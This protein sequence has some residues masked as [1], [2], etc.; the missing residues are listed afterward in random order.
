MSIAKNYPFNGERGRL[1]LGLNA[2][3]DSEWIHYESDFADRII[4]KQT[5]IEELGR[6]VLDALPS[7]LAAQKELLYLLLEYIR[8]HHTDKFSVTNSGVISKRNNKNYIIADYENN[9]LELVSYLSADDYCLLEEDGEDYKLVAASVCAPTWWK[10]SEKIG[11]PLAS[12]HE[13]IMNLEENI[14]RMIQTVTS[15]RIG[16]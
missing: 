8:L 16:F 4:Q 14:G 7:S 1:R 9:P 13:P 12:I 10:L 6:E 15:D 2:I 3:D 11:K 5:L